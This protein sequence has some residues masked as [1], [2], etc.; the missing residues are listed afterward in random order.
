MRIKPYNQQV[1]P[2]PGKQMR[3]WSKIRAAIAPQ[4]SQADGL[5]L[6]QDST[7][8]LDLCHNFIV[9]IDS[10]P[11]VHRSFL[12]NAWESQQIGWIEPVCNY[13]KS[14][15]MLFRHRCAKPTLI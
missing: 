4:I 5:F 10:I 8:F 6:L 3:D 14:R 1:F 13:S 7:Y 11:A 9:I 12:G 2:V 15:Q